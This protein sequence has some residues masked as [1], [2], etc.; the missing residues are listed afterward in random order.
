MFHIQTIKQIPVWKWGILFNILKIVL[1]ISKL[2]FLCQ[3]QQYLSIDNFN[4]FWFQVAFYARVDEMINEK[5]ERMMKSKPSP[6]MQVNL[7]PLF[8]T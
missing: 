1:C 4:F 6:Y 8:Q 2:H 3:Q 5:Y 7:L